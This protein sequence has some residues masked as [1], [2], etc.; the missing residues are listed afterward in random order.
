MTI[1]N[2]SRRVRVASAL[3]LLSL[4]RGALSRQTVAP[5]SAATT[6]ATH[7]LVLSPFEVVSEQDT[8]YLATSAQSGTRLPT[9]LKDIASSISVITK[10]FMNDIGAKDLE[11]L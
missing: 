5:D 11:S 8:G 9:E 6:A 7:P 10:D 4:A 3:L 1:L 2:T